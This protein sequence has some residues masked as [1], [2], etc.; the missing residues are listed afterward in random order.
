MIKIITNHNEIFNR[1]IVAADIIR[2]YQDTGS[3]EIDLNAEGP[4]ATSI[5]LYRMLDHICDRFKFNKSKITINTS[6]SEE[7]HSE[8]R[9]VIS[10]QVFLQMYY[11]DSIGRGY[12][13]ADFYKKKDVTKNLFGC[14]YNIP[15]WNRLCLLSYIHFNVDPPSLLAC[16]P[17][18]AERQHNTVYLDKVIEEAPSELYNVI[19]YLKTNPVPLSGH[20]GHK[21]ECYENMEILKFYNDFFVD[22]VAE[23]YTAGL[24]FFVTEKTVRP[25]VACTP[26]ITYGPQGFLSNLKARFGF[27]TFDRWWD[28][29]Y[30]DLQ[31][32]DRILSMYKVFDY[33]SGLTNNDKLAMYNDM[34]EVLA[35]NYTRLE[36]LS[37]I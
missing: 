34:L 27:K 21:P 2:E 7:L 29:S 11:E 8:Y 20:P 1:D 10:E 15:N 31:G 16:N 6:N 35:H 37:K 25:L 24:T 12:T 22:V 9:V 4:S 13:L 18:F 14:L 32:Y 33:L 23:T 17:T 28:E 36:E 5:G 30:D 19:E 26:F 3:A